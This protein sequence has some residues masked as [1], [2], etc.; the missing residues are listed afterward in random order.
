MLLYVEF[1]SRRAGISLGDFHERAGRAQGTWADSYGEDVM[2]LNAGRTW[3]IGPEPEY[4]CVW[5]SPRHGLTRIDDWERLFNDS[6]E[7]ERHE[8]FEAVARIDRAGCY[9]P[10]GQPSRATGGR[11][12]VEWLICD[13]ADREM[14]A[15]S[16]AAR[17]GRH[18]ELQLHCLASPLGALAPNQHG[19]A[20]WGLPSWGAAEA[21]IRDRPGPESGIGI[22]D[23]SLLAEFGHEQL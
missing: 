2:L 9:E 23:A 7:R 1:I 14:L 18:P 15:A 19:F 5:Y 6:H 16:F 11:Y 17:T 22:A 12:L 4:L 20:V 13:G 8:E 10:T 3:R 21:L